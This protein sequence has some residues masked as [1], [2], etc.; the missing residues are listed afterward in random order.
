MVAACRGKEAICGNLVGV[1]VPLI[2][3]PSQ[4]ATCPSVFEVV[5][6]PRAGKFTDNDCAVKSSRGSAASFP[7]AHG[8]TN[9][10]LEDPLFRHPNS[11]REETWRNI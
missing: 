8:S 10:Y 9:E 1:D 2:I 6:K 4:N 11:R 3:K 7:G 5:L